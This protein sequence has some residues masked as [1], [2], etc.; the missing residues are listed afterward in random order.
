MPTAQLRPAAA[1]PQA[2]SR[3][4]LR[5]LLHEILAQDS[6]HGLQALLRTLAE[7]TGATGALLWKEDGERPAAAPSVVAL[8][9]EDGTAR[10][11]PPAVDWFTVEALLSRTPAIP[12]R[13]GAN[14]T[15]ALGVPVMAALPVSY[16]DGLR[17]ALTL[18]G[19]AQL[20]PDAAGAV[21]DLLDVLPDLWDILRERQSLGLVRACNEVLNAADVEASGE[22]LAAGRLGDHL[23]DVCAAVAKALGCRDA[24]VFLRDPAAAADTYEL[25]ASSV[26]GV[27]MWSSVRAGV[28]AVGRAIAEGRPA[29]DA[30][31][32][33]LPTARDG[34]PARQ[35]AD[36]L[37]VVPLRSGQQVWGAIACSG[38]P[39]GFTDSDVSLVAP[40]APQVAQYWGDWLHRRTIFAENESWRALAAGITDINRLLFKE[41]R[42]AAMD[43]HRVYNA[44]LRMIRRVLPDSDGCDVC[45]CEETPSGGRLLRPVCGTGTGTGAAARRPRGTGAGDGGRRTAGRRA[46]VGSGGPVPPLA[47]DVLQSR[48]QRW[49]TDPAEIRA[50]GFGGKARWL[51][52]S[53]IRVDEEPYGV[54]NVYGASS[55]LPP[56]SR[57]VCKIVADQL[58]LYQRLK[59][60]RKEL[61]DTI[62]A[63]ADAMEDLQHQLVSPLL[64]AVNRTDKMLDGKGLT[65]RVDIDVRSVRAVRGLCRQASRV[66]MSAQIFA[67]LSTGRAP[68]ARPERLSVDEVIRAVIAGAD[69]AQLLGDA[70]RRVRFEVDRNS[71]RTLGRGRIKADPSFLEQCLGNLLDNAAK[72][73]YEGTRVVIWGMVDRDEFSVAVTSTGLPMTTDEARRCL[74]R[75]WRGAAAASVTG[76]GS[77]LGLWI[78]DNLM[79]SMGGAVRIGCEGERTTVRLTF[80][81]TLQ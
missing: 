19:D 67:A 8:W 77:G 69:D 18:L 14:P 24:C 25:L 1:G 3:V 65:G 23:A 44:A 50:E 16:P 38:P 33:Q 59:Q 2:G 61:E 75:A 12:S 72:Y 4:P 9:S 28:G 10:P 30:L 41:M 78:V 55:V 45:Q 54:L 43:D 68:S 5:R 42:H 62:R 13:D 6:L 63:Q 26:R 37:M 73:S 81:L 70:R 22:P 17:G 58:G 40:I 47:A 66:A 53:P 60:A 20:A 15:N 52:C 35:G 34:G 39:C 21:L 31:P 76:E 29:I 7:A 51:V 57:Q 32:E 11:A 79:R 80:P 74:D 46:A 49:T 27:P 56:S 71:V 36:T 48:D 64:V